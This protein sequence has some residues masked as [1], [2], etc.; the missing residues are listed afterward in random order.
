MLKPLCQ[1]SATEALGTT[2]YWG[3]D[4]DGEPDNLWGLE[5]YT[6]AVGFY[7]G[8][9]ASDVFQ[10]EMSFV[11]DEKLLKI[12]DWY[13]LKHYDL[14]GG[15]LT[16]EDDPHKDAKESHVAV[17]HLWARSGK[18]Q[19]DKLAQ[20]LC[21]FASRVHEANTDGMQSCSVLKG[22]WDLSLVSLWMR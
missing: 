13:D 19:Q 16:R 3:Q 15:F 18:G 2:Y 7:L 6:H 11:A 1:V 21:A 17:L 9:P 8:H 20:K 14:A 12:K 10:R 4:L 5:G 22:C